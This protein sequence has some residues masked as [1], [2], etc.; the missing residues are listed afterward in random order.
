MLD[1]DL[2]LLDLRRP[3]NDI[4]MQ[5][6]STATPPFSVSEDQETTIGAGGEECMKNL[7]NIR[8]VDHVD[9]VGADCAHVASPSRPLRQSPSL[10]SPS[11]LVVP[12]LTLTY[13]THSPH[14]HINPSQSVQTYSYPASHPAIPLRSPFQCINSILSSHRSVGD[15]ILYPPS[16]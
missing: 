5:S 12:F 7:V 3:R 6:S 9:D 14:I 15:T 8:V 16:T 2:G 4:V 10:F 13:P 11:T 1:L